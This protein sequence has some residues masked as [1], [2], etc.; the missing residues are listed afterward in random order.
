[1]CTGLCATDARML[2]EILRFDIIM[3]GLKIPCG[4]TVQALQS[5][6]GSRGTDLVDTLHAHGGMIEQAASRLIS[7]RR[8]EPDGFVLIR[9]EDMV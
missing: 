6:I 5:L 3:D 2:G 1:M 8:F 7:T 9:R 4:I